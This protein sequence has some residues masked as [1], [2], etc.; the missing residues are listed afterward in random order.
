M[1]PKFQ[2]LF[3]DIE[4]TANFDALQFMPEPS[5]PSNYK[6]ADKIAAYI[7]DKKSEQMQSAALD[8]DYGRIIAI[9]TRMGGQTVT[10]LVG[11]PETPTENDL[12]SWFWRLHS[13]AY[14]TCGYNIIGFDYPYLLRR[15][16]DLHIPVVHR[17]NL[18]KYQTTGV[19]DLMGILYNWGQAKGLKFVCKRY[20]IEN[21]LPDL[22]GS[23][24][25]TMDPETLRKYCGNDVDMT[26]RLYE[27]MA[28]VYFTV[29]E[30]GT[31]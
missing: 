21:P 4:T 29:S 8:A 24:V 5:A 26:A 20:G 19:I 13:E 3:F 22:D 17:P 9:G 31:L 10:H 16:M 23:M 2:T 15:S 6:D 25:E 11:D 18:A 27:R 12:I 28:G 14:S 30:S 7:A 1:K